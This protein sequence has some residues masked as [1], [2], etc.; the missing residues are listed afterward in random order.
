MGGGGGGKVVAIVVPNDVASYSFSK[1]Y[2]WLPAEFIV[3]K[4]IQLQSMGASITCIQVC[5]RTCITPLVLFSESVCLCS[6]VVLP[7]C[8]SIHWRQVT[9]THQRIMNRH[10]MHG[11]IDHANTKVARWCAKHR[12]P[13][14]A[15]KAVTTTA[16]QPTV[17]THSMSGARTMCCG[18]SARWVCTRA[19]A[20]AKRGRAGTF[21]KK[22]R[23]M[24]DSEVVR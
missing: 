18:C 12:P 10:M 5:T 20:S 13:P 6:S 2:Q 22:R 7:T 16:Y 3:A 8:A 24:L 1:K 17:V 15:M 23:L 9:G 14:R 19:A 11:K 21:T 4:I